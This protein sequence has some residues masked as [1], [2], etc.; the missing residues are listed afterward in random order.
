M[1]Q[2]D[3]WG[4]KRGRRVRLTTLPPS[5]SRL[6]RR[7]GSLDLSHPYGPSRP[8]TGITLLTFYLIYFLPFSNLIFS[9]NTGCR[10]DRCQAYSPA[11]TY[12]MCI[13]ILKCIRLK[14]VAHIYYF[15]NTSIA[16]FSLYRTQR[17]R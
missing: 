17:G 10:R 2:E 9:N 4:V 3:S 11:D 12:N 6:S 15:I 14:S 7:C 13:S 8:I 1:Y 16:D 5:V